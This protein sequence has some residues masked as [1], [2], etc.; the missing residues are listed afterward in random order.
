MP[1]RGICTIFLLIVGVLC[2]GTALRAQDMDQGNPPAYIYVSDWAVPRAQWPDMMKLGESDK[3]FL[4]KLLSDG[5]IQGYGEYVNLIHTED[6]P[7]H[8]SWIMASSQANILKALDAFYERP[9]LTA[10]V[11]AASKHWDYFFISRMHN[12]SPGM[13]EGA[14]LSGSLWTV[15]PGEGMAFRALLKSRVIPLFEKLVKDGTLVSYSVDLEAYVTTSPS[16]IEVV[17]VTPDATGLDKV[18][19]V[20]EDAFK[21]DAEIGPAMRTLIKANKTRDFLLRVTHMNTK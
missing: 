14:Y 20:F 5:T 15:K 7:T 13:H 21:D 3:P 6:G 9:D 17:L 12:W 2:A 16:Q 4:E 18:Q 10:P 8:G 11:L 1:R 19:S